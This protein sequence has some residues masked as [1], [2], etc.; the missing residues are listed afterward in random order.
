MRELDD[1]KELEELA[2]FLIELAI[3]FKA[4]DEKN[5]TA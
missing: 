2:K 4:E 5:Q 1:Q 3:R